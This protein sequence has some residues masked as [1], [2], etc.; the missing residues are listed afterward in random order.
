MAQESPGEDTHRSPLAGRGRLLVG[1]VLLAAAF[2]YF[3]YLG[4][5]GSS[6]YYLTIAEATSQQHKAEERLRVSGGLVMESFVREP[7]STLARFTLRDQ[8]R[9]QRLQVTYDGILP[10]LFFNEH[11]QVVAE[12]QFNNDGVFQSD[13]VLVKCPSKYGS[14]TTPE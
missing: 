7:G 4:F 10:D 11:T 3:A 2:G 13:L 9:D 1:G 8:D 14:E 5:Q 6:I 12:G